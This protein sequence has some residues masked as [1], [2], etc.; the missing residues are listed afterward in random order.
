[1]MHDE[2]PIM[3]LMQRY[4]PDRIWPVVSPVDVI[5]VQQASTKT[6]DHPPA[7][8]T[9][10]QTRKEE[11]VKSP[12]TVKEQEEEQDPEKIKELLGPDTWE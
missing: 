7:K 11:P 3:G 1:M 6:P 4:H 9:E 12:D 5:P 8:E 10:Q 2:L